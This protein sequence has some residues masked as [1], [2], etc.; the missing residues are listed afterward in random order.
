MTRIVLHGGA[1]PTP[2]RDY[3]RVE[4]HLAALAKTCADWLAEGITAIDVVE[5][6]VLDLEDSGLYVAGRGACPNDAGEYELDASIMDGARHRA[7]GVAAARNLAQPV[8]VARL[9]MEHTPHVLLA[10]EG[11]VAFAQAEGQPIVN[12]PA[13]W[14]VLPVG[15]EAAEMTAGDR[16]HGTVGA[17]A[18]DAGGRLAAATS[19][20]GVFGK[21]RGRVGDSP[22]IGLG[23]WAD[24]KVAVS[25]TGVG[26][27]F[28]LAGGA[29]D[30]AARMAY[31]RQGIDAAT[32][33]LLTRVAECGGDGGVIAVDV[34]G[35]VAMPFNS[36]GM[37]RAVAGAGMQVFVATF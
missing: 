37:K 14:F 6:A 34:A 4:A 13:N 2:G 21:R 36:A 7:G 1:G 35:N 23:T 29:Y 22:I 16:A 33:G 5:R 15:I 24:G 30:V 25:C 20:G 9:V 17:V 8:A 12:H 19:T 3:R 28:M 32:R 10:G 18:L 26:E 11:A 31:G 27:A